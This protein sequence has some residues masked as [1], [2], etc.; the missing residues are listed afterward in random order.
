M[1]TTPLLLVFNLGLFMFYSSMA[2]VFNLRL[3]IHMFN[4]KNISDETSESK[5][6]NF[7]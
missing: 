6:P 2:V 4:I 7:L 1:A 5:I 3:Y